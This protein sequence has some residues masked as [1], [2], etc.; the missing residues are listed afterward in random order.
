LQAIHEGHADVHQ[1]RVRAKLLCFLNRVDAV[2]SFAADRIFGFGGEQKANS[3]SHDWIVVNQENAQWHVGYG[4][5]LRIVRI[6]NGGTAR[7]TV[8]A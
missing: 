2:T 6:G 3:A 4:F 1:D 5:T 7:A 8:R